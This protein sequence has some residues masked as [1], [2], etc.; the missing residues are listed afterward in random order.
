MIS[1]RDGRLYGARLSR[2]TAFTALRASAGWTA[3]RTTTYAVACSSPD[4][5]GL[6]TTAQSATSGTRLSTCSISAGAILYPPSRSMSSA[7]ATW[8]SSP[9]AVRSAMSPV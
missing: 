6:P 7:R 9:V 2:S 8:R 4:A 5:S 3:S 1:T